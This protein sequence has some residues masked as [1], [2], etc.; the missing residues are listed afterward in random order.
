MAGR[1]ARPRGHAISVWVS[2]EERREI[3][4]LAASTG[5]PVAAYVS[6]NAGIANPRDWRKTADY[7]L[8]TTAGGHRVESIRVTN[9]HALEPG[10]AVAEILRTQEKNARTTGDQTYHLAV[11]FPPGEK[12]TAKTGEEIEV[13][14]VW[15]HGS[16]RLRDAGGLAQHHS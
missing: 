2:P 15:S 16:C 3:E 6:G 13:S 11:S 8:D 10:P 12:P 7:V 9:C 1:R 14:D 5:L 4:R